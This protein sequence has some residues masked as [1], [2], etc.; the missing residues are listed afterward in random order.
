MHGC[1]MYGTGSKSSRVDPMVE[2]SFVSPERHEVDS[3][4]DKSMRIVDVVR[5]AVA[6]LVLAASVACQ[7]QP[8][9]QGTG[10]EATDERPAQST[11]RMLG[12]CCAPTDPSIL[13][14]I[15]QYE[16]TPAVAR[17]P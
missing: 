8:P 5:A 1:C 2:H 12:S 14:L 3:V 16:A 13:A 7:G 10:A 6:A 11:P 9:A 17:P 15:R 4:D